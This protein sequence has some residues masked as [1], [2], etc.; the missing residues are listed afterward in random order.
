M[1]YDAVRRPMLQS[2]FMDIRI[3]NIALQNVSRIED[4]PDIDKNDIRGQAY[5]FRAFCHL[6]PYEL[7]GSYALCY[8]CDGNFRPVGP[9]KIVEA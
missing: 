5:F 3:A 2:A 4:G 9:S 7:L 6:F 1:T 8:Y